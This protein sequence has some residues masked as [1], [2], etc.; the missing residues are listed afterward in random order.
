MKIL[1]SNIQKAEV[2]TTIFQNIKLFSDKINVAFDDERVHIQTM[3]NSHVSIIEI[4]IPKSWFDAYSVVRT[5]TIGIHTPILFKILGTRDKSQSIQLEY[6]ND[7]DDKLRIQFS[8]GLVSEKKCFDKHFEM[9]LMDIDSDGIGI[10]DIDYQS[11]FTLESFHFS[12]LVNQLKLFGDT[13]QITCTENNI[14]MNSYQPESG[15]MSV[16]IKNDDLSYFEIEENKELNLS[17][18]LTYMYNISAFHKIAKDVEV[19][20][21]EDYP[22]KVIYYLGQ[23]DA[24]IS[25][26]LAPK[27]GDDD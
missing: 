10:P 25:F 17:F 3:D 23:E 9:P 1:I 5:T 16:E 12:N 19:N 21:S 7:Q 26:Y 15:K 13:I 24:K 11:K 2:F 6:D 27:I 20:L 22:M 14:M 18:S 4:S 8:D